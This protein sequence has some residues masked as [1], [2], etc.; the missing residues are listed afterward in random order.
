MKRLSITGAVLLLSFRLVV[1]VLYS[2]LT[3]PATQT[4][5]KSWF[6]A[7]SHSSEARLV[8]TGTDTCGG[9]EEELV[10]NDTFTFS[11]TSTVLTGA[12]F[13]VQFAL[14]HAC[15][16]MQHITVQLSLHLFEMFVNFR[17]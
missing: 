15:T 2:L 5:S 9:N 10:K 3:E 13:P 16:I 8:Y 4:T 6:S 1:S 17:L 7:V 11:S 12:Y 14:A